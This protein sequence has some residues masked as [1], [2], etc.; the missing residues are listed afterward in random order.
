[1]I[2]LFGT[3]GIMLCGSTTCILF[4][5]LFTNHLY[6]WFFDIPYENEFDVEY[7]E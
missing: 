3:I 2:L 1:M 4:P 6:H 7:I 5:K